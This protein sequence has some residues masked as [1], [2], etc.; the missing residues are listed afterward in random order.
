MEVVLLV[1]GI[2]G[3]ALLAMTRVI[4]R[5]SSSAG[6]ASRG[7]RVPVTSKH[8]RPS[9]RHRLDAGGD[10]EAQSARR[11][12]RLGRR[13][14]LGGRG[15]RQAQG[16]GAVARERTGARPASRSRNHPAASRG[17]PTR[18]GS[19]TTVGWEG[20]GVG[21]N[22]NGNGPSSR[23]SGP[24]GASGRRARAGLR[25][26]RRSPVPRRRPRPMSPRSP[27]R[28]RSTTTNGTKS[29]RSGRGA[30][31]SAARSRPGG[32]TQAASGAAAGDLRRG[33]HRP[34]RAGQHRAARRV[35]PCSEQADHAALDAGARA[36]ARADT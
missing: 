24:R 14:R 30:P 34:R 28:T 29:R 4:Q 18:T 9:R 21:G 27:A 6:P 31:D 25:P 13:P 5:R 12:E 16:V 7:S 2:T 10:L 11:R 19:R 3:I 20:A 32:T 33:G 22:G 8:G 1:L 26:S 17:R 36:D 15:D 23:A 35:R